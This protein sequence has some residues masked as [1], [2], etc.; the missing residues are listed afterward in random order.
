M[1][2]G[3]GTTTENSGTPSWA[4]PTKDRK[5]RRTKTKNS[6]KELDSELFDL[7]L[8]TK[9]TKKSK[10]R[11]KS[12]NPYISIVTEKAFK[13]VCE[14]CKLTHEFMLQRLHDSLCT[15]KSPKHLDNTIYLPPPKMAKIGNR[16]SLFTNFGETAALLNR[17][18]EH[19]QD[20][21]IQ[22]VASFATMTNDKR[23]LVIKGFFKPGKIQ[24]ILRNYVKEYV[25]CGECKSG[26]TVFEKVDRLSFVSCLVCHSRRNAKQIQKGFVAK[27]RLNVRYNDQF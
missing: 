20:F 21:V 11:S 23:H 14:P 6:K 2:S 22:E 27:T 3:M 1:D 25:E 18:P 16:K 15:I 8:K 17:T 24:R 4:L 7:D 9:K 5:L 26:K 13:F 10:T 19:L 12:K